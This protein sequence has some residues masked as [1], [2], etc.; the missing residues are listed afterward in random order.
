MHHDQVITLESQRTGDTQKSST[1]SSL[2][3]ATLCASH[4]DGLL[5]LPH[6]QLYGGGGGVRGGEGG[7][8]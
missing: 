7:G 2:R 4:S 6:P 1:L 8:L 3:V 5:E